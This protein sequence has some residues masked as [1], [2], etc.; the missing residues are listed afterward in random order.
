LAWRK[1]V[2]T[3]IAKSHTMSGQVLLRCPEPRNSSAQV[4][5]R[6]TTPIPDDVWSRLLTRVPSARELVGHP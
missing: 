6:S 2:G 1:A 3:L 4:S 5:K